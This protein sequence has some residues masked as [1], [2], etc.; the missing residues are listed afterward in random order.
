M[1]MSLQK[2]KIVCRKS[3]EG[4]ILD[5]P[6]GKTLEN[7]KIIPIVCI[8]YRTH[9]NTNQ[10]TS[11]NSVSVEEHTEVSTDFYGW[12]NKK[13]KIRKMCHIKKE[14]GYNPQYYD[15][16]RYSFYYLEDML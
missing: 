11:S 8:M 3:D 15:V 5:Y 13:I 4:E 1:E 7:G 10:T 6:S 14:N 9:N 2:Y 12:K 16:I